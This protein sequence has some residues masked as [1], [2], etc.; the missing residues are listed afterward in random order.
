[1]TPEMVIQI[2]LVYV[3]GAGAVLA[4]LWMLYDFIVS[5]R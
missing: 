3:F 4:L 2:V 5:L 1:M